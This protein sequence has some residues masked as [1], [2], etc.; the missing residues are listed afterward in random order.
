MQHVFDFADQLHRLAVLQSLLSENK[1]GGSLCS[2][3]KD[4]HFT[5]LVS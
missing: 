4:S 5:N 1:A 2:C 3:V